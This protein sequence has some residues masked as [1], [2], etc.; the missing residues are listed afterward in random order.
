MNAMLDSGSSF[1][2]H[3]TVP[4]CGRPRCFWYDMEMAPRERAQCAG[5]SNLE[6]P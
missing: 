2:R 1:E 6:N 5:G 3:V 4:S